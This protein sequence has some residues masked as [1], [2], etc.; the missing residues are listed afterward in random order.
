[1]KQKFHHKHAGREAKVFFL[2]CRLVLI[3]SCHFIILSLHKKDFYASYDLVEVTLRLDVVARA[4]SLMAARDGINTYQELLGLAEELLDSC[5]TWGKFAQ[6]GGLRSCPNLASSE[7]TALHT[8]P[9]VEPIVDLEHCFKRIK[10]GGV[11]PGNLEPGYVEQGNHEQ[12]NLEPGNPTHSSEGGVAQKDVYLEYKKGG[13]VILKCS[14]L[15]LAGFMYDALLLLAS[16]EITRRGDG[17]ANIALWKILLPDFFA[18]GHVSIPDKFWVIMLFKV[19][20]AIEAIRAMSMAE[21]A[22]GP[23]L[24]T[25]VTFNCFVNTKGDKSFEIV[26]FHIAMHSTGEPHTNMPA[27][28]FM[29]HENKQA[30]ED[31]AM[32]RGKF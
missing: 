12:G 28:M 26:A 14:H 8:S 7:I 24:A 25:D 10:E 15:P 22:M 5:L 31:I 6:S 16:K 19:K 1:M 18:T 4:L 32:A 29:E 21:G 11:A 30:K 17:K 3:F 2:S 13:S 20:Y 27:D 9:D 23:K